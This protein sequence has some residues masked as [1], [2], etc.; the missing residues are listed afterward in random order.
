M[1]PRAVAG[2]ASKA[3]EWSP[4]ARI[5]LLGTV[6]LILGVAAVAAAA[7]LLAASLALR[8]AVDFLLALYVLAAA[9]IVA[10]AL[11]LSLEDGYTRAWLFAGEAAVLV[12]VAFVWLARGRPHAPA[13]R[14]A[15][16]AGSSVLRDLVV[17]VPAAV[18][19]LGLAYLVA[20]AV[21]TPA[22]DYDVL[23]YHLPRAALWRQQHAVEYIAHANDLR[24][25]VFPPGAEIVSSWTMVLAG[26]DRYAG[27]FQAVGLLA[28]MLAV[29]SIA[30]RLGL[31]RRAAVFGA[32]LFATLPVVALQA[33][34]PLND[35]AVASFLVLVVAFL[36]SAAP[37]AVGLGALA[38]A[39]AVVTKATALLAVPLLL[40]LVG[41]LTPR[42]RWPTLAVAGAAGVVAGGCWYVVNLVEKGTL[43]PRFAPANEA[44]VHESSGIKIPAQLARL[45]VDAV[46]PAG[47][48]GRD[49][50]LYAVAAAILLVLGGVA[51]WRRRS[52]P[53]GVAVLV[54]AALVLLPIGVEPLHD[55]LLR[56]YQRA[57]LDLD[58][59]DLAFLGSDR[60]AV[61]PSAFISWYGPLGVLLVLTGVVLAVRE[62]RAG[63]VR[64]ALLALALAPVVYL[65]IVAV[66][67]GYTPFH[68]RYLMPAMALAAATWGLLLRVRA[69]GWAASAAATVTLVLSLVHYAEKPAGFAVLGGSA[70]T[71][72]WTSS[73]LEVLAHSHARG[74]AGAVLALENRAKAGDTV[75]L[76]IRQ[77]DVS[78]PFFGGSLDRRIVFVGPGGAGLDTDADWLGV[79]PGL[80]APTC[81]AGWRQLPVLEPDWKVY[82]RVGRCPGESASS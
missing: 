41:V 46:D 30:R 52:R 38:L 45:V 16:R 3:P 32:L 35:L 1:V 75:A 47:L 51:A 44:P 56:G 37:T 7:W 21:G 71:S 78:Y 20:L 28:T 82:R 59:P 43:V 40:L 57:L 24:L 25:N 10:L 67:I 26:E 49:R 81:A 29:A 77:D 62:I 22:N 14:P 2:A 70:A 53:L 23:W 15:V 73:R 34:T 48:V 66:G 80:T 27:L 39:L 11:V 9:E 65:V 8:S 13:L 74:G 79:A 64:R 58:H 72:V 42:R 6:Y 76:R 55:R 68:G 36:L 5:A 63:R 19:A 12:L 61:P 60:E 18:V 4:W 50:Y 17:A 33:S 54:A 31:D 69:L